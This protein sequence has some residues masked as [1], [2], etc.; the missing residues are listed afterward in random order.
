MSSTGSSPKVKETEN[1]KA[2]ADVA[3]QDWQRYQHVFAPEEE[4]LIGQYERLGTPAY[5]QEQEG[6]YANTTMQAA[7][8]TLAPAGLN[9][10]SGRYVMGVNEANTATGAGLGKATNAA[11]LQTRGQYL[12]GLGSLIQLGRNLKNSSTS[13]LASSARRDQAEAIAKENASLTSE[14]G[15]YGGLGTVAGAGLYA[16]ASYLNKP[17]K[18]SFA[19]GQGYY[20]GQ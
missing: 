8:S 13:G 18:P 5:Q 17:K 14:A 11:D 12:E 10:D 3:N 9:P 2:L 19:N 15:L 6:L 4:K 16:G 1:E 7:P 20:Y